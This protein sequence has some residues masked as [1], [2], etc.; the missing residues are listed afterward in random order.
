MLPFSAYKL[1]EF[2]HYFLSPPPPPPPQQSRGRWYCQPCVNCFISGRYLSKHCRIVYILRADD[3]FGSGRYLGKHFLDCFGVM[4]FDLIFNPWLWGHFNQWC[5]ISLASALFVYIFLWWIVPGHWSSFK[6]ASQWCL[7]I[8]RKTKLFFFSCILRVH[9][10]PG[11]FGFLPLDFYSLGKSYYLKKS[12]FSFIKRVHIGPGNYEFFPL[13][14]LPMF[15]PHYSLFI[16]E[17]WYK[18]SVKCGDVT[19]WK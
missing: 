14:F 18:Y 13:H 19:R 8:L 5:E 11:N 15:W 12:L 2:N 4:T 3:K 6:A 16:T 7:D 17:K 9:M 1:P 10:C